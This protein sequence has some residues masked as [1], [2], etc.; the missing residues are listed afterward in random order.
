MYLFSKILKLNTPIIYN[1]D[2]NKIIQPT[3]YLIV[4]GEKQNSVTI[5]Q[6]GISKVSKTFTDLVKNFY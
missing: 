3:S 1:K 5:Y 2:A 4:S 6:K